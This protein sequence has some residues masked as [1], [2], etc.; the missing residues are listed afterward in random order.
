MEILRLGKDCP[1]KYFKEIG[2]IHAQE[3]PAGF[4]AR[5]GPRFLAQFYLHLSMDPASILFASV[6][7]ERVQGFVSGTLDR[8]VFFRRYVLRHPLTLFWYLLPMA[9]SLD[10]YRKVFSI[11]QYIGK[12]SPA[13]E[14]TTELLSIAVKRDSHRKGL[15]GELYRRFADYLHTMSRTQ[16]V[17]TAA[18]TQEKALG[19]YPRMGGVPI[20]TT[21]I[22]DLKCTVF[23]CKT[24]R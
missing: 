8:N 3:I 20:Q 14:E 10:T 16:F 22:G 15:G 12:K 5:L 17:V 11:F 18:E 21:Q 2:E 6:E 9:F 23:L 13:I 7:G 1:R 19:F 4:L 24:S